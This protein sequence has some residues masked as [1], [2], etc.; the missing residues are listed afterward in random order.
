[1]RRNRES[2]AEIRPDISSLAEVYTRQFLELSPLRR[3]ILSHLPLRTS[4]HIVEPGCGTGLLAAELSVLTSASYTGIDSD[5]RALALAG[6][7]TAGKEGFRFE[8]ADALELV[9]A[10]DIYVSS[11]FL[12]KLK[13]PVSWLRKVRRA[14]PEGGLYAVFGEYDYGSIIEEPETG[15]ADTLRESLEADGFS[16]SLGGELNGA[17]EEAGFTVSAGGSVRG[18]LQEPDRDFLDLQLGCSPAYARELPGNS[19][20]SW[21]VVWGIYTRQAG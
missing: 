8:C 1:L 13:D 10:A 20:L 12:T 5:E 19:R 6:D 17:F 9:P 11:F 2:P 7:R 3:H 15:L 4:G 18:C 21:S 14:L 16:T